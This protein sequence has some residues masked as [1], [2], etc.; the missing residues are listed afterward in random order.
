MIIGITGGIATGKSTVSAYLKK[1]GIM[2][3][4]AD[5]IA[6]DVIEEKNTVFEIAEKLGT[7]ILSGK[8]INRKKLRKLVFDNEEK[9]K[10][11]NEIMHPKIVM[12]MK[13]LIEENQ[14]EKLLVFDIPLLY[15]VGFE[16]EVD[17]VVVVYC[18]AEIQMTRLMMRDNCDYNEAQNIIKSQMSLKEKIQKG[19]YLIE[20]NGNIDELND[21]IY[22]LYLKI[23]KGN[24]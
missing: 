10:E 16:T 5:M 17:K 14:N 20:N 9:L 19:D 4:D 24:L 7:N 21:K 2:V 1:M 13:T 22:E 6:K 18:A 12:K 3:F 23:K 11:L 8:K 15:E